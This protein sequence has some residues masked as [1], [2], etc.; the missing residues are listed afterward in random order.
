MASLRERT[1]RIRAARTISSDLGES[2]KLD[3]GGE[4]LIH[5]DGVMVS[6]DDRAAGLAVGV[7]DPARP[8]RDKPDP[9]RAMISGRPTHSGRGQAARTRPALQLLFAKSV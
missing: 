9:L 6:R 1:D 3:L 2:I 7:A 5:V 8:G 4:D